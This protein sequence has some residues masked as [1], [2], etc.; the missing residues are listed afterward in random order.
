MPMNGHLGPPEF[1]LERDQLLF[2]FNLFRK[3]AR[4]GPRLGSQIFRLRMA[5][6]LGF[7]PIVLM[8]GSRILRTM[9]SLGLRG[10]Y[11]R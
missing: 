1:D 5:S 4:V 11:V 7:S 10:V 3:I 8:S 2:E 6:E 9:G